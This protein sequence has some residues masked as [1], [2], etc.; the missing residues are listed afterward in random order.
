LRTNVLDPVSSEPLSVQARDEELVERAQAGDEAAFA[1]LYDIY[2]PRVYRYILARLG[3][4]ADAEDIAA[5]VFEKMLGAIDRFHWREEATFGAWVLRIA[6]NQIVTHY[7]RNGSRPKTT[8]L[9]EHLPLRTP[10]P[11][12]I[13]QRK[14]ALEEVRAAMD[15]LPGAQRQVLM[16]RF[17]GGLSISETAK[18]LGK[19][20]NNVKVLQHKGVSRLQQILVSEGRAELN[21]GRGKR[22]RRKALPSAFADL[23]VDTDIEEPAFIDD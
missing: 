14:L 12:E 20:E 13:V 2:F 23:D 6:Y 22:N 11:E 1:A 4:A 21:G 15:Q 17:A 7:R 8:P 19:Q 18:V 10:E 9:S 5:E 16:L 3:N